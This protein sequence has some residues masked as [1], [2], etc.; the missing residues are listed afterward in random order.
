MVDAAGA[1]DAEGEAAVGHA[2]GPEVGW[3]AALG[4]AYVAV[5]EV[6]GGFAAVGAGVAVLFGYFFFDGFRQGCLSGFDLVDEAE[7]VFVGESHGGDLRGA[8]M[9]VVV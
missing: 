3:E 1:A 4:V 8:R 9:K 5:A 6:F 2:G 7:E